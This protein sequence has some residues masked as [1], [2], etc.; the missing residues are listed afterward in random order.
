MEKKSRWPRILLKS[1]LWAAGVF[2]VM[3]MLVQAT[4]SEKVLTKI[5]NKY[6]AEYVDGEVSFGSA[7]VSVF[8][9]FP[10]V[11][12]A[13]EDF[14]ITYP[15]E[16]GEEA[17]TLASFKRFSASLDVAALMNGTI[18]IPHLRL[19]QPRIF[20]HEYAD[21]KANWDIIKVSSSEETEDTTSLALP[22]ISLGRISLSRH[23]HIVYTNSKDTVFAVIDV[24]R[25]G[26]NGQIETN[27]KTSRKKQPQFSPRNTAKGLTVD[28]LR[29]AGRIKKDTIALSVKKFYV[30]EKGGQMDIDAK[31][32]AMLATNAFGRIH[33]PIEISGKLDFPKDTIPVIALN[34][35]KANVGDFPLIA[36][37]N[38]R[39]LDDKAAIKA[40]LGIQN[41]ALNDVFHG[42]AENIIPELSKVETD[43]KLTMIAE[44]DGDYIFSS[45]ELPKLSA[46]ISLP[47]ASLRYSDV[48]KLQMK[49]GIS[50]S[51]YT[52]SQGRVNMAIER[53]RFTANGLDIDV[54]GK[55]K[56]L[57]GGD[58]SINVDGKLHASLD[59]L[60]SVLPDTLGIIANGEIAADI[61]GSAV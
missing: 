56:D 9:R 2:A 50:A 47:E 23:P 59:T 54:K 13:L 31:A 32:K 42:F 37:A 43:A 11:F 49:V 1:T 55:G 3:L 39:I 8:K 20:A 61:Q 14:H 10:R 30:Q 25:I 7:S 26:F 53:F 41:C 58:P 46:T 19:V 27:H 17:D 38:V 57:L 45:G 35:L 24:A 22:K 48:E 21:G 5:I 15:S 40:R 51:G 33:L 52:D 12:L 34:G 29:I 44:C 28:S 16:R 18:K 60:V 6:A 4:L 36:D